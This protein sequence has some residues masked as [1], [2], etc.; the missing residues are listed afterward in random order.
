MGQWY[1]GPKRKYIIKGV[2]LCGKGKEGTGGMNLKI[3]TTDCNRKFFYLV[4]HLR[5]MPLTSFLAN[6]GETQSRWNRLGLA[7]SQSQMVTVSVK[8]DGSTATSDSQRRQDSLMLHLIPSLWEVN[9]L[10]V[11]G[12]GKKWSGKIAIYPEQ[13]TSPANTVTKSF[14][15]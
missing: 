5:V 9:S 7:C 6:Q 4:Y 15:F 13:T 1:C 10:E 2:C 14:M 3:R 12:R 8:V 11:S